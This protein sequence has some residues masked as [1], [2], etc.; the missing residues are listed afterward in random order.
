MADSTWVFYPPKPRPT[1]HRPGPPSGQGNRI[2]EFVENKLTD[3]LAGLTRTLTPDQILLAVQRS[4][5]DGINNYT[6]GTI[7]LKAT[8][9]RNQMMITLGDP[10]GSN[11][12][13]LIQI[14]EVTGTM[15]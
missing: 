7:P 14:T 10:Q 13:F 5:K 2:R 3:Q 11:Q 4:I 6:R 15:R 9:R 12:S 1:S 8:V